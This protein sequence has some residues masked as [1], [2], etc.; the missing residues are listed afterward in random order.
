MTISSKSL[1]ING[2]KEESKLEW[3]KLNHKYYLRINLFMWLWLIEVNDDLNKV[4]SKINWDTFLLIME[5]YFFI[6]VFI[7]SG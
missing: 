1:N 5:I 7:F 2:V 6:F 3:S 4:L